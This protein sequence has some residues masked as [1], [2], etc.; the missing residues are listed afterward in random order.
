MNQTSRIAVIGAGLAGLTAAR[1]LAD[2]GRAVTVFEKSRGLGGRLATRRTREGF[3]FD[4]GAPAVHGADEAFRAFL[5]TAEAEGRAARW[6]GATVGLP[7]MSGLV[8]GLAAGL[9]IRFGAEVE[10]VARDG[11]GWSVMGEPF[12]QVIVAVPAPQAARLCAAAPRL[13]EAV[14]AARMSPCWTLL[15]AFDGA[16]ADIAPPAPFEK[17]LR[18]SARPGRAPAPDRWVAHAALDWTEAHLELEKSA[19]CDL[20]LPLLAAAL[21]VDPASALYAAAHRWRFARTAV[22]VGE[23][24]VAQDGMILSGDW[25]LGPEAGDAFASGQA[26]AVAVSD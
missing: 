4:H 20:L 24:C 7:G 1:A 25:L 17:V 16:R 18:S 26:A 12:G 5:T 2:R 10:A 23:A 9:D 11:A 19:A 21:G 14:Q 3:D 15:A 6:E 8:G 13:V 22:A